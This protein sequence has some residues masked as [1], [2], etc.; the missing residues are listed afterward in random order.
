M[1]NEHEGEPALRRVL[2]VGAARARARV[3]DVAHRE[4]GAV[5]C[6][7]ALRH[8][9]RR[10]A[11]RQRDPDPERVALTP[12]AQ[13][14]ARRIDVALH[15]VPAV[16]RRGRKRALEVDAIAS[17]Q[18]TQIRAPQRFRRNADVELHARHEPRHREARSVHRNRRANVA[19]LRVVHD[20]R[21]DR[22]DPTRAN[23]P[24][25]QRHRVHRPHVHDGAHLFHDPAEDHR[26]DLALGEK[27]G[28][29]GGRE[30]SQSAH[31]LA[32]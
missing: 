18:C 16:P 8:H 17:A 28:R 1:L 19:R 13:N 7:V 10:E 15:E 29:K 27:G 26:S 31:H 25:P 5:D 4:R 22:Q 30:L 3:V 20:R 11:L 14:R 21:A 32:R 9:V 23:A 2:A 24:I 6:D 12:L